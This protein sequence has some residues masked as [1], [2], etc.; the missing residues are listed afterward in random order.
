MKKVRTGLIIGNALLF[1]GFGCDDTAEEA[2]GEGG[3]IAGGAG[4]EIGGT[5]GEAGG[6]GG[7][8]GAGG[9]IGGAGGEAGGGG[10]GGGMDAGVED[11]Q[12]ST[13]D[14][15]IS[16]AEISD[17]FEPPD[18]AFARDAQVEEDFA[19]AEDALIPDAEIPD[20]EIPDAGSSDPC[21]IGTACDFQD[22][23]CCEFDGAD[24]SAICWNDAQ[25]QLT[26]QEVPQ[27]FFC[28]CAQMPDNTYVAFCA[29]PGF[30]GI[31]AA[32]R[33]RRAP[34][35]LRQLMRAQRDQ[36]AIG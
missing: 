23:G 26:W 30:V 25:G 31:T 16:D 32:S 9:E 22:Q 34:R 24:P 12:V 29:V 11:A 18:T 1:A 4:G 10:A 36:A 6:A 5:G 17:A 14:A 7:E 8:A 21:A 28:S 33:P 35:R 20:A 15:M 3:M 27:D 19:F 2:G 13:P